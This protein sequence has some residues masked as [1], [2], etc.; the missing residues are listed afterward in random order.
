VKIGSEKKAS[1]KVRIRNGDEIQS[2]SRGLGD[3]ADKSAKLG[4][5]AIL[6]ASKGSFFA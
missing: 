2:L 4:G 5:A 3:G 1:M 6:A